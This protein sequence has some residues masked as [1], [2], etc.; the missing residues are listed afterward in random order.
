MVL[1]NG[2]SVYHNV[3]LPDGLCITQ[4]RFPRI[5]H[6]RQFGLGKN[7]CHL[8][9]QHFLW[10]NPKDFL[11]LAVINNH[12]VAAVCH[13]KPCLNIAVNIFRC[14]GVIL[15]KGIHLAKLHRAHGKIALQKRFHLFCGLLCPL[16]HCDKIYF[17]ILA[18][19]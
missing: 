6:F 4:H 13:H 11:R 12:S 5:Y 7:L 3:Y 16:P 18:D 10:G 14:D 8:F 17:L 15:Q 2:G 9:S 1:H 19:F